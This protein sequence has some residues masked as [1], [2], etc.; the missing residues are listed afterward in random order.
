MNTLPAA[1]TT[2]K[3][4]QN[5]L[6]PL[7]ILNAVAAAAS[8]I[9]VAEVGEELELPKPTVHRLFQALE[10]DG[11][12]MRDLAGRGYVAGRRLR[13][14]ASHTLSGPGIRRE[15]MAILQRLA[16]QVG[17][18]CNIS[19]PDG[20]TMVYADRVETQ[21]PLR[22]QLPV[23]TRVPLH[24]TASGKV[25]LSTLQ[26]PQLLRFLK[27]IPLNAQTKNSITSTDALMAEVETVRQRG[28]AEDD[29][30]MI[31]GMVA[32]AVPINDSLDR[33]FGTVSFHAPVQRVSLDEALRFLPQLQQVA[34]ELAE[35]VQ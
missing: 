8:P 27:R 5:N 18:T 15:R 31:D 11:W 1:N 24:C 33:F 23:G 30:E 32:L 9:T 35:T 14:L 10:D 28:F 6:R 19:L 20:D 3:V 16:D 34:R 22:I 7:Y 4:P 2:D 29:Q 17:E 13:K 25:Y 26:R 12:L 21:W